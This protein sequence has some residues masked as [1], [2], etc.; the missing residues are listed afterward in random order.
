MSRDPNPIV[1]TASHCEAEVTEVC[2]NIVC[3]YGEMLRSNQEDIEK[4]ASETSQCPIE[5]YDEA[6][7]NIFWLKSILE[8]RLG[9][10]TTHTFFHIDIH[11]FIPQG[12]FEKTIVH[13]NYGCGHGSTNCISEEES[14]LYQ[15]LLTYIREEFDKSQSS[16]KGTR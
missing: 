9:S 10:H 3:K 14:E 6:K 12:G 7:E 15:E 5:T 16:V 11:R 2:Y 4:V 1:R 13:V 8:R